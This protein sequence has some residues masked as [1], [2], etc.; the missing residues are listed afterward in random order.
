[1]TNEI[2]Q[3]SVYKVFVDLCMSVCIDGNFPITCG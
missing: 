1:M 3:N 2:N